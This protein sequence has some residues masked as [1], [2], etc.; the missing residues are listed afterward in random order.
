[1]PSPGK[2]SLC[3][4]AWG[5]EWDAIGDNVCLCVYDVARVGEQDV[6]HV[7]NVCVCGCVCVCVRV[8]V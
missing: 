2:H 1:M 3:V 8:C 7:N 4:C 6:C 5:G